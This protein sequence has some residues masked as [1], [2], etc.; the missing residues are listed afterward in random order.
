MWIE[1]HQS[2]R[3]HPKTLKLARLL[4]IEPYAAGGLVSFLWLWM[5]DYAKDGDLTPYE[6]EDIATASGWPGDAQT[7]VD[8][9]VGCGMKGKPG[10]LVVVD[11]G[12]LV[13]DWHDY[14]GKLVE[15]RKADVER[16]RAASQKSIQRNSAE[17]PAEFH[18]TAPVPNQPN[19]TNRTA[20]SMRAEAR[21]EGVASNPVPE[22]VASVVESLPDTA[23]TDHLSMLLMP[24][25]L[26]D[27]ERALLESEFL[28][29]S[30][31][32]WQLNN[33]KKR[34]L[35]AWLEQPKSE[36]AKALAWA[37][38]ADWVNFPLKTAMDVLANPVK[39]AKSYGAA[40]E[41]NVVGMR[42][43][44]APRDL[45][46]GL[47]SKPWAEAFTT[48]GFPQ[49]LGGVMSFAE[50]LVSESAAIEAARIFRAEGFEAACDWVWSMPERKAS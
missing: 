19:L 9:L 49:S 45:D 38:E 17:L 27:G 3:T 18:R 33:L 35:M 21:P 44:L 28:S 11:G 39:Y 42:S 1:L 5:L 40:S 23:S 29:S 6:I 13:H 41:A 31:G 8:A 30:M 50:K 37:Q 32:F 24:E 20:P 26:I 46:P 16:K 48:T 4:S 47:S 12:H 7:L 34:K 2:L 15:K 36:R 10:F 25:N 14:A 43:S 22:E